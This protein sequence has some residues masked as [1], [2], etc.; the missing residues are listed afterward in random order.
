MRKETFMP[1]CN[2][3]NYSS[4]ISILYHWCTINPEK[5]VYYFLADTG[6]ITKKLNYRQLVSKAS[7][8]AGN[9]LKLHKL[10]PGDRVL[11]VYPPSLDFIIAFIACLM[12]GVI[13]VP[14][15]PP[16]PTRLLKDTVIFNSILSS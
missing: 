4:F 9:L 6:D 15:F 16:D 12:S 1:Q 2:P 10:N 8:I 13:A 5:D 14:A 11:L 7:S 3:P